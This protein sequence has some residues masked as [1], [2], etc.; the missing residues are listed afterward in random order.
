MSRRANIVT[1]TVLALLALLLLGFWVGAFETFG[2]YVSRQRAF[3]WTSLGIG[4]FVAVLLNR[5]WKLHVVFAVT[6]FV[7]A[8]VMYVLGQAFGQTFYVGINGGIAD[9]G[10]FVRTVWAALNNEL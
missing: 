2:G 7:F 9:S 3:L 6:F 8:H 1:S 10:E 4:L 5:K